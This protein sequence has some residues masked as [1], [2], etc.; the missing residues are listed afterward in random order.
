MHEEYSDCPSW[1][2][3]RN[4]VFGSKNLGLTHPNLVNST[5]PKFVTENL[6]EKIQWHT[7]HLNSHDTCSDITKHT[8]PGKTALA[9]E[10]LVLTAI[11]NPAAL[12]QVGNL[13]RFAAWITRRSRALCRRRE[14]ERSMGLERWQ[15]D[16]ARAVEDRNAQT[17]EWHN[18][19]LRPPFWWTR[20]ASV[21][22]WKDV[23]IYAQAA[24]DLMTRSLRGWAYQK[25]VVSVNAT[26]AAKAAQ[27]QNRYGLA[28]QSS[29]V[30]SGA[31]VLQRF[32]CLPK[33]LVSPVHDSLADS[34][35]LRLTRALKVTGMS[36]NVA[37]DEEK[38]FATGEELAALAVESRVSLGTQARQVSLSDASSG[39][40]G[41][42]ESV[43]PATKVVALA[44]DAEQVAQMAGNETNKQPPWRMTA[45][46]KWPQIVTDHGR[47]RL[48][49]AVASWLTGCLF[50]RRP[51]GEQLP[52]LSNGDDLQMKL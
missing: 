15:L 4:F 10:E 12:T 19:Q 21:H 36:S 9:T 40:V 39:G 18:L 38:A 27:S 47:Y 50:G 1:K 23:M 49:V 5:S 8:F 48:S 29:P 31:A 25:V 6:G 28:M 42:E 22:K 14:Y 35:A 3:K 32:L 34:L 11:S 44:V 45:E 17:F 33:R 24:H 41:Y 2:R 37:K 26:L 43:T 52:K 13:K 7:L 51:C 46:N 16:P 30:A 20:R